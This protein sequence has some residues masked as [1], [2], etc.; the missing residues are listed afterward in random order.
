L[1]FGRRL[2]GE[3]NCPDEQYLKK[4]PDFGF[5]LSFEARPRGPQ[6]HQD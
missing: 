4:A 1:N 2:V 5:D 6:K 3:K